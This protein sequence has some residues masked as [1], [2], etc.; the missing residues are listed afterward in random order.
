MRIELIEMPKGDKLVVE[1]EDSY[2]ECLLELE[3]KIRQLNLSDG[4]IIFIEFIA[5][6]NP[7]IAV[8]ITGLLLTHYHALAVT[9]KEWDCYVVAAVQNDSPFTIGAIL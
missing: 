8:L 6:Q 4:E 7:S 1:I 9:E 5:L 3:S 2:P